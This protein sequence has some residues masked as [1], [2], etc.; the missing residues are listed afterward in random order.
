MAIDLKITADI[1]H[2]TR[3][4]WQLT[5]LWDG[6][7]APRTA[8]MSPL[9]VWMDDR[10]AEIETHREAV[11]QAQRRGGRVLITGL[12]LAIVTRLCLRLL[13]VERVTVVEL[14]DEPIALVGRHWQR[15]HGE[16]LEIIQA[17]AFTWQPPPGTRFTVGWH[18]PWFYTPMQRPANVTEAAQLMG[19]YS[20]WCDWQGWW[21]GEDYVAVD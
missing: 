13:N 9:G 16:R 15:V 3:G 14:N 17:D 7:P 6:N 1:R 21:K 11:E 4:D 2:A 12:G 8:L 18:D 20:P 5:D 10:P 19:R